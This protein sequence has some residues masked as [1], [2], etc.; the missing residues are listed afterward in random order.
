MMR[1]TRLAMM[2][3][4]LGIPLALFAAIAYPRLWTL[5]FDYAALVLV[6]ILIDTALDW[7]L[8]R[9]DVSAAIPPEVPIGEHAP[10]RITI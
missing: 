9:A 5:S 8:R 6:V 2:M 10:V 3:F 4:A 7:P 1:P